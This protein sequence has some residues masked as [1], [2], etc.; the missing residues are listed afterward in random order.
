MIDYAEEAVGRLAYLCQGRVAS[1]T[2]HS[3]I[4]QSTQVFSD[5]PSLLLTAG[6]ALT[7]LNYMGDVGNIVK[8]VEP[9]VQ[10]DSTLLRR[11]TALLS[12]IKPG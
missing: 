1:D 5:N 11:Y 12:K 2:C 4:V 7:R 9:E 6:E 3:L 8:T 10:K